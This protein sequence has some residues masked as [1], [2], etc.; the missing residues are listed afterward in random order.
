MIISEISFLNL[1]VPT[2]LISSFYPA[3]VLVSI[4][5]LKDMHLIVIYILSG[6]TRSPVTLL[7]KLLVLFLL[8]CFSFFS[9]FSQSLTESALWNSGKA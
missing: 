2:S 7:F 8:D 4:K 9:S 5:Q 3:G 6:G 1:L